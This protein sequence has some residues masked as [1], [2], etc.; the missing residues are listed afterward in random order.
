MTAKALLR[1][2]PVGWSGGTRALVDRL[3]ARHVFEASEADRAEIARRADALLAVPAR[4]EAAVRESLFDL[5]AAGPTARAEAAERLDA[6][7]AWTPWETVGSLT[8]RAERPGAARADDARLAA[9]ILIAARETLVPG[10][11]EHQA[12]LTG[13]AGVA[14]AHETHGSRHWDAAA[15]PLL[16]E[17][18]R[19]ARAQGIDRRSAALRALAASAVLKGRALAAS[20]SSDAFRLGAAASAL[21]RVRSSK[22]SA[23]AARMAQLASRLATLNRARAAL[24]E[25]VDAGTARLLGAAAGIAAFGRGT[26]AAPAPARSARAAAHRFLEPIDRLAH[27]TAAEAA[28]ALDEESS[29]PRL[30]A[31]RRVRLQAL[32]DALRRHPSAHAVACAEA[33]GLEA[34]EVRAAEL[35]PG[36]KLYRAAPH[37]RRRPMICEGRNGRPVRCRTVAAADGAIVGHLAYDAL[38]REF[39]GRALYAVY[40][41]DGRRYGYAWSDE[42]PVVRRGEPE[43]GFMT[44]PERITA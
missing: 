44:A 43:Q 36:M 10:I 20:A 30:D 28:A 29:D 27:L 23:S 39:G 17:F 25:D 6:G 26:A 15:H 42:R 16:A 18:A 11:A 8:V 2:I 37:G 5:L 14:A 21:L 1:L 19:N 41:Q 7:G 32:A 4:D 33:L 13:P 38:S 40:A 3:A 22:T 34:P 35:R 9:A 12:R 31:R 24:W